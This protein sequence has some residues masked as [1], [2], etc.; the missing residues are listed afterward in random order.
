MAIFSYINPKNQLWKASKI[1]K[2][3]QR[4]LEAVTNY[5]DVIRRNPHSME[6]LLMVCSMIEHSIDNQK[7]PDKLKINKKDLC[8]EIMSALFGTLK[9]E[10]I[11]S[12]SESIEFLHD[13]NQIV[14]YSPLVVL[15]S[16]CI[17]WLKRKL[18]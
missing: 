13:N 7:K 11:Q 1:A 15:T 6:L 17:D 9:P 10:D 18:N 4:I 16:T 12:I 3:K 2:V 8:V 5:P 14:R